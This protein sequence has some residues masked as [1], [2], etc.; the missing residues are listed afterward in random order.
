MP[1]DSIRT[2]RVAELLRHEIASIILN[3]IHDLKVRDAV[4]TGAKV[5]KDLSTARIY[6]TSYNKDALPYIETSLN[7]SAGFIHK[8]LK[9]KVYL[10]KLPRIIFERDI[11]SERVE[12][13]DELFRQLKKEDSA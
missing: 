2:R 10:K 1:E 8:L 9:G 4:I 7:Q 5:T 13:L 6:F 3:D 12:H 11:T